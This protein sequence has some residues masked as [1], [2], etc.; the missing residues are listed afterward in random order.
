[1]NRPKLNNG[2]V[3]RLDARPNDYVTWCGGLPGFGVR[4]RPSGRKSFV[5][6]YD[7]DRRTR[8]VTVGTFPTLTVDQARKKAV[9]MLAKV[10]L[11]EDIAAKPEAEE[12]P[13]IA[14]LCDEYLLKGC[15]HKK[16]STKTTDA[17][18]I[19]NHIKPLMGKVLVKNLKRRHVEDFFSAVAAGDTA[20]DEVINGKRIVVKG[21]A[22][23]AR[24]T[25]RLFGG[26]LTYAV[27]REY[28]TENPRKGVKIGKDN[29]NE[30]FLY[31]DELRRLGDALRE[32]ETIGLPWLFNE[33]KKAKHRPKDAEN[34]REIICPYAIAAI[35]LLLLT[36]CRLSEILRLEWS[37]VDLE[38]GFLRLPDSKTGK[39]DVIL[40]APALK[41]LADIPRSNHAPQYVI[42]G[43]QP[44][45]PRSDLKRPWRRIIAHA[46]LHG[47]R[48]HDLRHSFASM[49]AASGMGLPIVGKLLGHASPSTTA[50]Y[51]H[52][53]DDPLRRASDSIA[54]SIAAAMG[55][56]DEASN[57]V[58]LK[59]V[60]A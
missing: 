21:G 6:Q 16:G 40:G 7:F 51:A 55:V 31:G 46:G 27:G 19:E 24:R 56:A 44:D 13:S 47:L 17:A 53:A 60:V 4:V 38:R 34:L 58:P 54:G 18:A 57:V 41:V 35:R 33:G 50:R 8:K 11:G 1:M 39:K 28:I 5:V 49:G 25:V 3:D 52:L 29:A 32:A 15:G 23:A 37:Q 2:V 36:G 43:S 48:L 9:E 12:N 10:Q 42:V 26:I 45:K 59:E 20:K 30:R 14:E 22:G